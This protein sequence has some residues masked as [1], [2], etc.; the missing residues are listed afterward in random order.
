VREYASHLTELHKILVGQLPPGTPPPQPPDPELAHKG[1][2]VF[3]VK[4]HANGSPYGFL[5][6][7]VGTGP[8]SMAVTITGSHSFTGTGPRWIDSGGSWGD[9]VPTRARVTL[10][11][12]E[13]PA[14]W[15]EVLRRVAAEG[16]LPVVCEAYSPRWPRVPALPGTISGTLTEVLDQLCSAFGYEW[17]YRGGVYE[18]RGMTWYVS[19]EQEPPATLV[20]A[21]KLARA[22]QQ[23]LSL[24]WLAAASASVGGSFEKLGRL[25]V[26]APAARSA[27]MSFSDLLEF[28]ASLTTSQREA[29]ARED[30]LV[31][32]QLAPA[33]RERLAGVLARRARG[34]PLEA[35]ADARVR[36]FREES[37]VRFSVT[38]G[39]RSV[40][41]ALSLPSS[42][43]T[44]VGGFG[45][46]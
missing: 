23:P 11:F 37:R 20:K 25:S 27:L 18:F 35:A 21:V 28:Y 9:A 38:S 17:R 24:E 14:D 26:H 1:P 44:G 4:P 39:E 7:G 45:N 12:E 36:L 19:R 15:G 2:L 33:Q 29:L 6:V 22:Q 10:R 32:A 40:E 3:S 46:L 5:G 13:P 42:A 43:A 34:W 31:A 8:G 30:G 16:R 41:T